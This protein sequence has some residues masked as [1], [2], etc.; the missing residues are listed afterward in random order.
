MARNGKRARPEDVRCRLRRRRLVN[1]EEV[2]ARAAEMRT[3]SGAPPPAALI[4]YARTGLAASNDQQKYQ[5]ACARCGGEDGQLASWPLA[6][7]A[8]DLDM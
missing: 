5:Y 7:A 8:H 1:S 6:A 4:A 2:A 3:S